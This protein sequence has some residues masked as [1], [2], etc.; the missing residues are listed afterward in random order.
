MIERQTKLDYEL[1]LNNNE[2]VIDDEADAPGK[3]EQEM[4]VIFVEPG[5]P[6]RTERFRG[7]L[8]EMQA[9]VGGS[10]E[11]VHPFEDKGAVLICNRDGKNMGLTPNRTIRGVVVA[12]N[13]FVCAETE[14]GD[15][16]TSPDRR[17]MKRYLDMFKTPEAFNL[18]A[19]QEGM[20]AMEY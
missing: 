18:S 11:T 9:M 8:K 13:F 7:E 12:G 15:D 20:N 1:N 2:G 4:T 17:Q 14:A 6:A 5:K 10:I 3:G 16:F 19:G